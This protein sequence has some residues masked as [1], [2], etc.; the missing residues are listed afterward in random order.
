MVLALIM[1][2]PLAT[3]IV[4]PCRRGI[5]QVDNIE[6]RIFMLQFHRRVSSYPFAKVQMETQELTVFAPND[7]AMRQFE[8]M[9]RAQGIDVELLWGQIWDYHFGKPPVL[10]S[11]PI[12]LLTDAAALAS[13]RDSLR[14]F[15]RFLV[16]SRARLG[17]SRAEV[18]L[19]LFK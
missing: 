7:N 13:N 2:N 6:I 17:E 9:K 5:S 14:G 11:S 15:M 19:V 10:P 3:N 16:L 4:N 1:E 18:S 8:K 12:L